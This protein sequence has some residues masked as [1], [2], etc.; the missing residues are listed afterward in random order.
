M[1]FFGFSSRNDSKMSLKLTWLV[2]AAASL[3]E[4]SLITGAGSGKEFKSNLE[5][6]YGLLC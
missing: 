3:A 6:P 4:I 5:Y 2:F 1:D